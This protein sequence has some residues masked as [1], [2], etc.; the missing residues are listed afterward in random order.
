MRRGKLTDL[1]RTLDRAWLRVA[2]I[3]SER[4]FLKLGRLAL[5]LYERGHDPRRR[6][7]RA[8][9]ILE[10]IVAQTRALGA[11]Y[12]M[13]M[14]PERVQVETELRGRILERYDLDPESYDLSSTQKFLREFCGRHALRCL[15][16]LE[17]FWQQ[18]ADGGYFLP[19]DTHLNERGNALVAE[20]LHAF[21]LRSRALKLAP[22]AVAAGPRAS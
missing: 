16:P 15:D 13:V 12:V 5:G 8:E 9:A 20:E 6:W 22:P 11:E 1:F 10:R 19:S 14:L 21:L 3:F 4:S 7:G 2:G 18:A 17:R